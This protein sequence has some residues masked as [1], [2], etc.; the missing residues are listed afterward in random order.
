M[1][2]SA[3]AATTSVPMRQQSS[4]SCG[5]ATPSRTIPVARR[6][7]G[8]ISAAE[9]ACRIAPAMRTGIVPAEHGQFGRSEHRLQ[10]AVAGAVRGDRKLVQA[11]PHH[12][13]D[14]R[15]S[16]QGRGEGGRARARG[17]GRRAGRRKT[18]VGRRNRPL[19][20][21]AGIHQR[22]DAAPRSR[23]Q[24]RGVLRS[25]A[26][27]KH[28]QACAQKFERRGL[29]LQPGVAVESQRAADGEVGRKIAAHRGVAL[30]RGFE[31][32]RSHAVQN[33]VARGARGILAGSVA[34]ESL[35]SE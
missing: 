12:F 14:R 23:Q 27:R 3:R 35:Q 22:N 31:Q 32:R 15:A 28:G 8:A 30:N 21:P 4:I 11:R 7:S 26:R 5:C 34:G 9:A 24:G 33:H 29:R 10:A 6:T 20:P 18:K 17:G 16:A 2:A 19:R 25:G 1:Q 13:A